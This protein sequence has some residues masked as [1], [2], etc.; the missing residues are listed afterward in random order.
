LTDPIA[1]DATPLALICHPNDRLADVR[2]TRRWLRAHLEAGTDVLIPEISDYEVRRE[3][4][5]AG[6]TTSLRRLDLLQDGLTYLPLN[7]AVMRRAAAMWAVARAQGLPT[8]DRKEIDADVILAAQ[9][10]RAGAVV[11]TAN[12]GHIARFVAAKHWRDIQ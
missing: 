12:V 6:K 5:R 7:T 11:A 9:A 3:L 1:L 2:D 8:A 4:L 10:E